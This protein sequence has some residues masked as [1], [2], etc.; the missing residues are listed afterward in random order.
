MIRVLV[1]ICVLSFILLVVVFRSG[2]KK[3]PQVE[4]PS[5][6]RQNEPRSLPRYQAIQ[7]LMFSASGRLPQSLQG[8]LLGAALYDIRAYDWSTPR[9]DE[10]TKSEGGRAYASSLWRRLSAFAACFSLDTDESI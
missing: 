5:T 10:L 3:G 6:A 1:A 7:K 4:T 2:S 8:I 9:I